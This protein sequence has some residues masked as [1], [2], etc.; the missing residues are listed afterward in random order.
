[1]S[2]SSYRIL[3]IEDE[4]H[5]AEGL[6]LNFELQGYEVSHAENGIVALEM[7]EKNSKWDLVL[8]DLMLPGI[9]GQT[10]IKR[11]RVH[12]EKL[13]IIVV[14]AK[15]QSIDKV[16]CLELGVDDY[17]TKPFVL[18]ELLLR[19]N[20]LLQRNV[21]AQ[22]S[23]EQKQDSNATRYQFGA[24]TV[25]FIQTTAQTVEGEINLTVQELKILKIFFDTPGVP[26]TRDE[27]LDKGW[28]ISNVNSRTVD[29]FVVRLRK[30]FERDASQPEYFI[31][32]RGVGYRFD[33]PE[34]AGFIA[35]ESQ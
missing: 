12:D 35:E 10:I 21:W 17:I 20:R 18:D 1:M 14:S 26:I 15:D 11:L 19:V 27:L 7:Y 6:K 4:K 23:Q 32:I 3:I 5:I 34:G 2:K 13:P 24:N 25:D 8:V 31:S 28:G 9:D 29:N 16:K 30:Y 22:Q 33:P